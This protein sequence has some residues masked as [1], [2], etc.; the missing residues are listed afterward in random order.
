M[1]VDSVLISNTFSLPESGSRHFSVVMGCLEPTIS[2]RIESLLA[3]FSRSG[4]G[5]MRM[6]RMVEEGQAGEEEQQTEMNRFGSQDD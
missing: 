6:G 3:V 4:Y 5:R 1:R 2:A